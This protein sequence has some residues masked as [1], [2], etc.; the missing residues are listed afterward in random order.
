MEIKNNNECLMFDIVPYIIEH[1]Q[2][3][4]MIFIMIIIIILLLLHYIIIL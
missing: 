2:Y 3:I 4:N 1:T